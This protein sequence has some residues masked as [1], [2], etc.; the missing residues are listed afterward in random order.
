M[1][2]TH[3]RMSDDIKHVFVAATKDN[4]DCC[5]CTDDC[6]DKRKCSCWQLTMARSSFG[7]KNKRLDASV[8]N[9]VYE[10]NSKCKCSTKCMTRVVQL[11]MKYRFEVFKTESR[12][13]GVRCLYD[14]PRGTFICSYIGELISECEA[15]RKNAN[16]YDCSYLL[17]MASGKDS[18]EFIV[19]I[20]M[21]DVGD[22][23]VVINY[24]PHSE[25]KPMRSMHYIVDGKSIGNF[26]KFVN[27]SVCATRATINTKCHERPKD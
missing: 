8:P 18:E 24:V 5:D 4:L 7:Y 16:N 17:S 20:L 22:D 3:Y 25:P 9:G 11:P 23:G 2:T 15:D 27:V 10:C 12:G 26:G 14:L 1:Y 21:D 6:A 13:W 19:P